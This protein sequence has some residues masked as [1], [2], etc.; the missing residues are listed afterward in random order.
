MSP[1]MQVKLLSVL[2][3]RKF[4][5]VGATEETTVDTRVI[6]A[7]NRDLGNMVKEGTFREDLYY[8]ISVIP[9]ELPPLRER[10]EDI[11]ELAKHFVEKF[12]ANVGRSLTIT[13]AAL[14][15]LELYPWPE[16]V[17]ELEHAIQRAA[18]VETSGSI[19][20][21]NLPDKIRETISHEGAQ[22]FEF[23]EEEDLNLPIQLDRLEKTY[24]I[25]ALRRTSGHQ[26][27]AAHLLGVSVR[28]LRHLL[29]KHQIQSLSDRAQNAAH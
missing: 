5:P 9:I 17:R 15:L 1:A 27:K 11:P 16:N 23:R 3:E 24:V 22:D 12:G 8:R 13:D 26:A 7:T 29:R 4:R 19:Q 28:S 6:A 10:T 25:E 18:M 21:E 2:Q 14:R 20:P